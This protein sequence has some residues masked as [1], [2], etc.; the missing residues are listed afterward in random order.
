MTSSFQFYSYM[1]FAIKIYKEKSMKTSGLQIMIIS[2]LEKGSLFLILRPFIDLLLKSAL[3]VF[4][5]QLMFGQ[6]LEF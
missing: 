2:T 6:Y 4:S 1:V 5:R 3:T